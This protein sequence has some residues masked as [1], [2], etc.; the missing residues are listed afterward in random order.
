LALHAHTDSKIN[1]VG[2]GR[3]LLDLMR[4]WFLL[5]SWRVGYVAAEFLTKRRCVVRE[6]LRIAR[7]ANPSTAKKTEQHC[8]ELPMITQHSEGESLQSCSF[9]V[10]QGVEKR[11]KSLNLNGGRGRNRIFNQ[12]YFQQHAGQRM[13]P[14]TMESSLKPIN[15]AQME[16]VFVASML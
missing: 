16:R 15:G 6:N 11:C 3:L 4:R 2:V 5:G 7:P 14:K 10:D 13:T 1:F 9:E 12:T 8:S